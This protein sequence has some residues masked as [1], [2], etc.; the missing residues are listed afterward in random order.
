ME[1][2]IWKTIKGYE[3]IYEVSN[4]GRVRNRFNKILK[5]NIS[6]DGYVHMRLYKNGA[7]NEYLLHRL[8]LKTF[9]LE[10]DKRPYVNHIDGNKQNN[11][12]ENLEWVNRSENMKHAYK[13]GLASSDFCKK[14]I[15]CIETGK[16]YPSIKEC[17]RELK[18]YN[19]SI[20]NVL[21][22]KYKHAGGK[23]FKYYESGEK[24]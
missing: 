7:L 10:D 1:K 24:Y 9:S 23:H 18:L 20:V 19:S 22:G 13:I 4:K 3:G 21:K 2:E 5:G 16:V 14:K 8:V 17:A 12:L 15:I 6:K 11:N